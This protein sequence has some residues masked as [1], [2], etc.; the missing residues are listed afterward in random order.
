MARTHLTASIGFSVFALVSALASTGCVSTEKY[1]AQ[2]LAADQYRE[3]LSAAQSQVSSK[4][5]ATEV[6]AQQMERIRNSADNQAAL[7]VNQAAT[8]SDLTRQLEETKGQYKQL[9]DNVGKVA[10]PPCRPT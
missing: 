6:Y 8:I 10:R 3:Q 4:T 9:A 2:K 7:L 5:S 1:N